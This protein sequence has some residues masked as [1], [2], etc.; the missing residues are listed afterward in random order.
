M[1]VRISALQTDEKK[2]TEGVWV[3]WLLGTEV[4]VA[5][6]TQPEY[7]D[8]VAASQKQF[9][10]NDPTTEQF[11]AS[12]APPVCKWIFLGFR[13]FLED[14]GTEMVYSQSK[15]LE[16][17]TALPDLFKFILQTAGDREI[18]WEVD[19]EDSAGN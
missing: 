16:L 1:G 12:I 2:E 6:T 9:R 5:R 18:F 13:G 3:Q 14:D 17:L 19:I 10:Q 15:A 7:E 8:A 11:K 4:L